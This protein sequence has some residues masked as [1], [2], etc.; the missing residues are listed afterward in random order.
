MMQWQSS[1]EYYAAL[2]HS[3]IGST[4][5]EAA[6]LIGPLIYDGVKVINEDEKS[7]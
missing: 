1:T 7:T 2:P 3:P 5:R 4:D 6:S